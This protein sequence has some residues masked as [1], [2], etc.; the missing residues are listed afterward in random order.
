MCSPSSTL[1]GLPKVVPLVRDAAVEGVA[2]QQ[3]GYIEM[4]AFD[5]VC[6]P[7]DGT[8]ATGAAIVGVQNPIQLKAQLFRHMGRRIRTRLRRDR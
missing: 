8:D 1:R 7:A 5:G 2:G 4:A 3:Q 6:R